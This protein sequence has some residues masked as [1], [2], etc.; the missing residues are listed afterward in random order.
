L[1]FVERCNDNDTNTNSDVTG[2]HTRF[3]ITLLNTRL[4]WKV[5]WYRLRT[6]FFH[7]N[8]G[9]GI[10]WLS[11]LVSLLSLGILNVCDHS[12]RGGFQTLHYS[13][14]S[15]AAAITALTC[16]VATIVFLC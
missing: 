4:I 2:I 3:P 5:P 10:V 12:L 14:Y 15:W 7:T 1:R 11:R 13:S 8:L 6:N 16:L 9:S